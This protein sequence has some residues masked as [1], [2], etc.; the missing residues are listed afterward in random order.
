M[1]RFLKSD[2]SKRTMFYEAS[3]EL[4][5]IEPGHAPGARNFSRMTKYPP[6]HR[7]LVVDDEPLIRWS[8][9][10]TLG[11]KGVEVVEA[12]DGHA[13][14]EAVGD[15]RAPFDVVLLDL[16]LP[17]SH[18]L[19]LLARLRRVAPSVKVIIMTAYSTP[20]IV[21]DALA[22]GAFDVVSKPF[23]MN[24]LAA[25]VSHAGRSSGA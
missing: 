17:D 20:E 5:R 12:G 7:V 19:S 24:E 23:E 1:V 22:L 6:V 21:R 16:R 11:D 2:G 13:A 15:S 3:P 8:V 9:A 4:P 10:E 18:D 25:L 14:L